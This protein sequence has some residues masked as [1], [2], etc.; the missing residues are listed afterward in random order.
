MRD[1]PLSLIL[2]ALVVV[3]PKGVDCQVS[4]NTYR[5]TYVNSGIGETIGGAQY[6]TSELGDSNV[7]AVSTIATTPISHNVGLIPVQTAVSSPAYSYHAAAPVVTSYHASAPA[8]TSYHAAVPQTV[9]AVAPSIQY[10]SAFPVTVPAARTV[11][12][13]QVQ[14]VQPVTYYTQPVVTYQ[15][16]PRYVVQQ[17]VAPQREY[18]RLVQRPVKTNIEKV[19]VKGPTEVFNVVQPGA[20]GKQIVQVMKEDDLP[21]KVEFVDG[22][23]PTHMITIAT[24]DQPN[25]GELQNLESLPAVKQVDR[26]EGKEGL[27][28]VLRRR[29]RRRKISKAESAQAKN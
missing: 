20:P 17:V 10:G 28:L 2:L 25:Q 1:I 11:A 29:V 27:R 3:L 23:G 8:L 12:I 21:P 22:G 6:S 14:H 4:Y 16:Q 9:V 15:Q 24:D 13:Q 18:V 19:Q 5:T 7:V 26:I